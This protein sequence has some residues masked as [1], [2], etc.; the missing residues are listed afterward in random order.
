LAAHENA[1]LNAFLITVRIIMRG[2]KKFTSRKRLSGV[3]KEP[4]STGENRKEPE[5][6][7]KNRKVPEGT[8]KNR[9]TGKNRNK[10]E[11]NGKFWK[12]PDGTGKY[13]G[14]IRKNRKEPENRKN[15]KTKRNGKPERTGNNRRER[16]STEKIVRNR[17]LCKLRPIPIQRKTE[18][19]FNSTLAA[20]SCGTVSV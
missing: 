11:R 10:S 16:K 13:T 5:S 18:K 15:G 3:L 6:T 4:E 9:K 8:G 2:C 19:K 14:R 17:N 20:W 7:G 12:V 1:F